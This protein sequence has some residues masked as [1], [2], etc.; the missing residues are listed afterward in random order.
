MT[1]KFR[2]YKNEWVGYV[3][4]KDQNLFAD[5]GTFSDVFKTVSG[6]YNELLQRYKI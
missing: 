1:V 4:Y 3:I 5:I 2:P 6:K